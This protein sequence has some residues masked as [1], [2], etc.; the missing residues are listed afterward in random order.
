MTLADLIRR[1]RVLADDKVQPYLW[2]DE[3]VID[4]LND[5]QAQAAVRGRLL[6]EDANPAVCNITLAPGVHTYPLHYSV[7][8]IAILR[9]IPPAGADKPRTIF[10]KSREWL[11]REFSNWRDYPSP[12]RYAIQED[13][14]LRLVGGFNAGD[15]LALECY[16]LPLKQFTGTNLTAKPEIH[17][18]HHAHLIQWA[19]HRAYGIPDGDGFDPQRSEKAEREFTDYF[20]PL[21]DSDMRRT[22]RVDEVHHNVAVLP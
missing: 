1:F 2:A 15:T 17:T 11:D 4:W 19:L 22:T 7:F 21:P 5:A 13:T 9:L 14:T 12:A 18:A 20:G 8:E 16:R 3:D 10:L 6:R